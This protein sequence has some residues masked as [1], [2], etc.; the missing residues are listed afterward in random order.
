LANRAA[1]SGFAQG[2]ARLPERGRAGTRIITTMLAAAATPDLTVYFDGSCPLCRREI[3][4]YQGLQSLRPIRWVDVSG[5]FQCDSGLTCEV[6]MRRFHVRDA[7]GHLVSGAQAFSVL[8]RCFAGWRVLGWLTAVPPVSLLA[9]AA[10]R[11][12]LPLRPRLQ[13]WLRRADVARS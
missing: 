8:W 12:F 9:E 10:Y 4:L 2:L 11:L 1:K 13:D 6:A 3:A 7:Q 5:P